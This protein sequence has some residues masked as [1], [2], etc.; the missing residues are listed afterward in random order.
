MNKNRAVAQVRVSL[1]DGM[2]IL[3]L[4]PNNTATLAELRQIIKNN[5]FVTKGVSAVARGSVSA[6]QRT[7]AVS[8]TGEQ[9]ALSAPPQRSGEDWRITVSPPAKP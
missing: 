1:N 5:G 4:K 3:D 8:G 6:D 9:L 2:T 7:F